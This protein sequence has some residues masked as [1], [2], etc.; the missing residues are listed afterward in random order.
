MPGAKTAKNLLKRNGKLAVRVKSV[1]F[2]PDGTSFAVATTEGL[3][4]YSTRVAASENVFE[5]A[6]I[7]ETVT[8]DNIIKKVKAEE[9]TT[10]LVLALRLSEREVTQTVYK[11]IPVSSV[12]LLCAHFP[13]NFL[14]KLLQFISYEIEKGFHVEWAMIW[15]Q[16]ILKFHGEELQR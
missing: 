6:S 1:K 12:S 13:T 8:L 5:P 14:S 10:A 4:L 3:V 15:L 11:C 9:Y 16:N 2:S 7:D